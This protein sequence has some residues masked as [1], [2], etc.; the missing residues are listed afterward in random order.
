M[1]TVSARPRGAVQ[2]AHSP[3]PA[4]FRSVYS[5]IFPPTVAT[6]HGTALGNSGS[7]KSTCGCL[8]SGMVNKYK[9]V[10]RFRKRNPK[11]Y[12]VDRRQRRRMYRKIYVAGEIA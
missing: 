1:R 12:M 11:Y 10:K 3:L 8:M 7:V 6:Y 2:A 5:I 4:P 9:Y